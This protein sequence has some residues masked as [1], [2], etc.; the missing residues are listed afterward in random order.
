[1]LLKSALVKAMAQSLELAPSDGIPKHGYSRCFK[2]YRDYK[3]SEKDETTPS[4]LQNRK[5]KTRCAPGL[6]C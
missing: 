4:K 1:V 6:R 5:L 3:G 2:S